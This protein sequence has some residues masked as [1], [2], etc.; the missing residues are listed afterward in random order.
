[1]S[2]TVVQNL[3]QYITR[4]IVARRLQNEH[5]EI[6]LATVVTSSILEMSSHQL[7]VSSGEASAF[8]QNGMINANWCD[9]LFTFNEVMTMWQLIVRT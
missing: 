6:G 4:D 8:S 3:S 1:M 2:P 7:S 9:G 5:R